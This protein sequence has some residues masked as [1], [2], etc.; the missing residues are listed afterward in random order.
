MSHFACA[1]TP[2]HPLNDR[3]IRLFREIRI[4]YRGVPSS[5]ANSSGIFLGGTRYCDMVRPGVALY[6]RQSDARPQ[7]PMRPVVELQGPHHPGAQRAAAAKPSATARAGPPARRAAIAVVAVGYADGFL[8]AAGASK[9]K[10]RRRGHR[11][12]QALPASSAAS[13]WICSRST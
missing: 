10:R 12:G 13:R 1:E 11:R 3:Q 7:N 4:L 5:L 9:G 6:R 8:R 2:D